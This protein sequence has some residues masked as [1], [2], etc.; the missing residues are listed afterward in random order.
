M[1]AVWGWGGSCWLWPCF[2]SLWQL[3][4]VQ[5]WSRLW[6][7]DCCRRTRRYRRKSVFASMRNVWTSVCLQLFAQPHESCKQSPKSENSLHGWKSRDESCKLLNNPENRDDRSY[8]SYI[9]YNLSNDMIYVMYMTLWWYMVYL[10]KLHTLAHHRNRWLQGILST[11]PLGQRGQW[12]EA[13]SRQRPSA[14][15]GCWFVAVRNSLG[16][17]EKD[18][19]LLY[20]IVFYGWT[21]RYCQIRIN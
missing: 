21:S 19:R 6:V 10:M 1:F 7:Q 14:C 3:L 5:R 15:E 16:Q 12:G 11:H 4:P 18:A 20:E 13:R 17:S 9:L 2:V 8:V